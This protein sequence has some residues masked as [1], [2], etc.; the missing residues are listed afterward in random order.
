[1]GSYTTLVEVLRQSEWLRD[2]GRFMT[3]RLHVRPRAHTQATLLKCSRSFAD[4]NLRHFFCKAF[5]KSTTDD[6]TQR[7][8]NLLKVLLLS[9][10]RLSGAFGNS[11]MS[12]LNFCASLSANSK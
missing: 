2:A 10:S 8:T 11:I 12:A 7:F 4:S 9:P 6:G 1:M 3:L 5:F